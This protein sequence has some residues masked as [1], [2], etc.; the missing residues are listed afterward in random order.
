VTARDCGIRRTA[1]RADFGVQGR[2][3]VRR[4][5]TAGRICSYVIGDEET[6]RVLALLYEVVPPLPASIGIAEAVA[7]AGLIQVPEAL[8]LPGLTILLRH[9]MIE[10]L[11]LAARHG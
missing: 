7:S 5:V 2:L 1:L 9:Q 6:S 3:S 4:E 10:V 11:P 8:V